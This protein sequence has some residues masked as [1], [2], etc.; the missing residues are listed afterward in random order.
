MDLYLYAERRAR[1]GWFPLAYDQDSHGTDYD[2]ANKYHLRDRELGIL[3]R[4][5]G[6]KKD[7]VTHGYCPADLSPELQEQLKSFSKDL[8]QVHHCTLHELIVE[9]DWDGHVEIERR[10]DLRNALKLKHGRYNPAEGRWFSES[11]CAR[12]TLYLQPQVVSWDRVADRPYVGMHGYQRVAIYCP[13]A[14][15]PLAGF[16]DMTD[17]QARALCEYFNGTVL[18][19]VSYPV[20]RKVVL[21]ATRFTQTLNEIIAK[22]HRSEDV[23]LKDIRIIYWFYN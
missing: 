18:F 6:Q 16:K 15:F 3:Q 21:D 19:E 9:S 12:T 17:K 5:R 4:T 2:W 23:N 8:G 22:V 20:T 13:D 1:G 10:W 14:G 7:F 11:G